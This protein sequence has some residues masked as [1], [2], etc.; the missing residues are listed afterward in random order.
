MKLY[1]ISNRL[2]LR[3]TRTESGDFEFC[4]SEG[5]L[6]TGLGSL[7]MDVE[8]HWIGWPGIYTESDDEKEKIISYLQ[9]YN[10]I[11]Y[12]CLR[13]RYKTFMKD[14]VTVPFGPCVITFFLILSMKTS[15]GNLINRLMNFFARVQHH[16]L[17]REILSGCKITT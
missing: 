16:C 12:F 8:K 7:T 15:T 14:T 11:R 3:A 4:H 1:I 13:N 9:P 5:G 10:F 6:A 2:P 17:N